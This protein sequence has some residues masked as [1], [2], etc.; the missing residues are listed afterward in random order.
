MTEANVLLS[1]A[2]MRPPL[3]YFVQFWEFNFK[4]DVDRLERVKRR[5]TKIIR[6]LENMEEEE[7]LK[8]LD[9]LSPEKRRRI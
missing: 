6:G 4:K 3:E 5:D 7:M 2:L 9:L 8:N 1:S